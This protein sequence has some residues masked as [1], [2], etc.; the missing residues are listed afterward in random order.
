VIKAT[1]GRYIWPGDTEKQLTYRQLIM[2]YIS[3]NTW[4]RTGILLTL[5]SGADTRATNQGYMFLPDQMHRLFAEA[6]LADGTP[7]CQPEKILFE[8]DYPKPIGTGLVHPYVI[9]SLIVVISWVLTLYGK[10]PASFTK[11]WFTLLLVISGGL[12]IVFSYMWFFSAFTVCHGNLNLAW[13]IPFNLL[14]A[15]T[16]WFP[17][18]RNI[19]RFY[20]RLMLVFL[21]LFLV[22]FAFWK[23]QVPVEAILFCFALLPGFLRYSGLKVLRKSKPQNQAN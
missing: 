13:A 23:Q 5:A 17:K 19:N 16:L 15:I 2:P 1:N 11:A 20:F 6:K 3:L 21:G 14:A 9:L 4:A 12:G 10:I 22:T 7:L 8:P 18:A